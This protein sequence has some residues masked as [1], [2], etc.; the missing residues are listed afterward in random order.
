MKSR[1]NSLFLREKIGVR[2]RARTASSP[3]QTRRTH[4]APKPQPDP[5]GHTTLSCQ[6]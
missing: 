1:Y 2:E 4:P 5:K 3:Q 6:P